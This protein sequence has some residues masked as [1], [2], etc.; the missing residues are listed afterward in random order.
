M[1]LI[2]GFVEN[3]ISRRFITDFLLPLNFLLKMV[4]IRNG[5]NEKVFKMQ[6]L[7]FIKRY[8]WITLSS[9]V[10]SLSAFYIFKADSAAYLGLT[11][12]LS[13]AY[14]KSLLDNKMGIVLLCIV[15][16]FLSGKRAILV[17]CISIFVAFLLFI[18]KGKSLKLLLGLGLVGIMI[19]LLPNRDSISTSQA[20]N[21]LSSTIE[22]ADIHDVSTLDKLTGGRFA[23]IESI[24]ENMS[25]LDYVIGKGVGF[26]YSFKRDSEV[27]AEDYGNAHFSPISII[28]KYGLLFFITFSIYIVNAVKGITSKNYAQRFFVLFIV[29]CMIEYLFAYGIFID[30][31][32]PFALGYVQ[33][34][35]YIKKNVKPNSKS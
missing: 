6:F 5:S 9:A 10:V 20:G 8:V 17:G 22:T 11:P 35:H 13:P 15:L 21:K 2:V 19:Y 16:A 1:S 34:S 12:I 33:V 23:E 4:I 27:V 3:E 18:G 14:I 30:K 29:G 32:L 31:L 28:S 25:F 26:T 24:N 7:V